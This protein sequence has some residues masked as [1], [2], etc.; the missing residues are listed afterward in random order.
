[1]FSG[2]VL[3]DHAKTAQLEVRD[4]MRNKGY[5]CRLEVFVNDR[6]DGKTGRIDIVCYK[7][8]ETIAIEVD[9]KTP[10]RKSIFKLENFKATKKY[11]I[12]RNNYIKGVLK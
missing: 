2:L 3:T 5:F 9:R 6:G 4:F 8:N 10:R 12:C 1:M 11:V 7:K